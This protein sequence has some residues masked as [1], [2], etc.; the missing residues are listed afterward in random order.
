MNRKIIKILLA[1]ITVT[2]LTLFTTIHTKDHAGSSINNTMAADKTRTDSM[3]D[4]TADNIEIYYIRTQADFD[5][6]TEVLENRNG[7]IIIEISKGIVLD[8]NG[9]GT[10][11]LGNYIRYENEFSTGD[12]V[13]SIFVYSPENNAIDDIVYRYDY[14]IK[15]K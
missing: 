13:Q 5:R 8:D 15:W 2:T 4:D 12:R 3:T 7:K 11:C 10:D 6:L 1:I 9:N 14:L